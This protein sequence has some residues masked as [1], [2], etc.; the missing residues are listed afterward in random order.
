MDMEEENALLSRH[1]DN[2]TA[3]VGRYE[4]EIQNQT[5]KN[6][7]LKQ[8]LVLLQEMLTDAFSELDI[9]GIDSVPS[10]D[11]IESYLRELEALVAGQPAGSGK[12]SNVVAKV[13]RVSEEVAER[14]KERDVETAMSDTEN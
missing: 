6:E 9:P 2:M 4:A 10:V 8:H 13:K 3:Q 7:S 11:T 12:Y 1:V 14:M 5:F